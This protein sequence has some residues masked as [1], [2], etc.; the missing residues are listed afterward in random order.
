MSNSSITEITEA[1]LSRI[2]N[3]VFAEYAAMYLNIYTD[4]LQQ[5]KSSG[6]LV[7]EH[8]YE[9]ETI[10]I[11]ARLKEKGANFRN[12]G[13]SVYINAISPACVAC[14][15][16]IGSATFFVSLKCHRNCYF[17]FNPN[18]VDYEYYQHENRN[19]VEELALIKVE[20]HR[21]NHL[22]ITGGEPL[23]HKED[24]LACFRFA[25]DAFPATYLRLYTCGDAAD[26]EALRQL[27]D[28]GLDE[29]RFSIRMH[30]L[31]KGHQHTIERIA[32]AR[33]FIPTVMV[34]MPVLPGAEETM[35]DVL[36]E[37]D[38]LGIDSINL[39]ELCYPFVNA[40]E[41]NRRSFKIRK[42]PY[43]TLYNYWY[44]GGVP[45]AKSELACLSLLE[46]ALDYD[47]RI[48]VHYCSLENKL[49][50][51]NYHQNHG[52]SEPELAYF[53]E[54]DFL[55]KS[56][57]VFG[58]DIARVKRRL[59]KNGYRVTVR[60]RNHNYLE[61]HVRDIPSL[62]GM[63][64]EVGISTSTLETRSDGDYAR[65]LKV[66]LTYPDRFDPRVDV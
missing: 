65:E 1:T 35:K 20:G 61:F 47:I 33:E 7:D 62:S 50:G 53:S 34:E 37:L 60:N 56:A 54:R 22:A 30:D 59:Q 14:K 2:Q 21:L 13:R 32:E 45:I 26:R 66:D 58:R 64:V 43:K 12:G 52:K 55:F 10:D 48:G 44:A 6:I 17:C 63:D 57:K 19:L 15:K 16:G 8:D 11:S 31:E 28:A 18:Q 49:T 23:L 36:L 5:V 9:Q 25:S 51:Q 46:F 3:P 42:R 24:V 41:F 27:K 38:Q 40:D 4:F 29:I 39:L